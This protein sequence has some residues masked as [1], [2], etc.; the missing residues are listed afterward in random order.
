MLTDQYPREGKA[1]KGRLFQRR[2]R[3]LEN[4][5]GVDM[6]KKTYH[7]LWKSLE[8]A[9]AKEQS[10][11]EISDAQNLNLNKLLN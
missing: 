8:E 5:S 9:C 4:T 3:R 6:E 1:R 2:E 10:N 7:E 11:L